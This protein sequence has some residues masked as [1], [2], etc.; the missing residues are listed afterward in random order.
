MLQTVLFY[1]PRSLDLQSLPSPG[2]LN[3]PYEAINFIKNE[4]EKWT[5]SIIKDQKVVVNLAGTEWKKDNMDYDWAFY[6]NW[7]AFILSCATFI[8]VCMTGWVSGYVVRAPKNVSF[9]KPPEDPKKDLPDSFGSDNFDEDP[10][11][12]ETVD[13]ADSDYAG[14]GTYSEMDTEASKYRRESSAKTGNYAPSNAFG[15]IFEFERLT[16]SF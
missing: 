10:N 2:Q 12:P 14:V 16:K 15:K 3:D 1:P 6:T 11:Y 4:T 5:Q 7:A 13:H 9:L 8:S